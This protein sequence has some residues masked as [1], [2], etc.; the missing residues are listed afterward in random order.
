MALLAGVTEVRTNTEAVGKL[1]VLTW[2]NKILDKKVDYL[3]SLKKKRLRR[4]REENQT[5]GAYKL[6]DFK[7]IG[8]Y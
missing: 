4:K 5:K 3:L 8:L 6:T 7:P 1:R 2:T